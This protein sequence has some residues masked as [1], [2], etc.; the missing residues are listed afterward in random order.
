MVGSSALSSIFCLHALLTSTLFL[1]G[2]EKKVPSRV[3][4]LKVGMISGKPFPKMHTKA[5]ETKYLMKAIS[6]LFQRLPGKDADL[7]L[8]ARALQTSCDLDELLDQTTTFNMP[9]AT[10]KAFKRN[11]FSP[12]LDITSMAQEFI[13]QGMFYFNFTVKNHYLLHI[14]LL[15]NQGRNP[16]LG[17]CFKG[18]DMM[19]RTKTLI[20]ASSRV[21]GP[22]L[23]NKVLHKYVIGLHLLSHY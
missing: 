13:S 1:F 5:L 10:G 17:W 23:P 2:Q 4:A 11:C 18:G 6:D 7:L 3:T 14:G 21:P 16:K 12:N 20:Q 19:G 22:G 8:M 9:R 15:A